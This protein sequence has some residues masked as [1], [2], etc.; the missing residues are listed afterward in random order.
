TQKKILIIVESI[1]IDNSS[2]AKGRVS[3]IKNLQR[4]GFEI[5]VLHYSKK[6]IH[7][8]NLKCIQ[9][10]E[11]KMT[12]WFLLSR[13][14]RHLRLTFKI[15]IHKPLEKIFG[16]SFTLFNDRKSIVSTLQELNNY[17]PD[18]VLTLS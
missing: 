15:D 4:A 9:I 8:D 10:A 12:G 13:I 16:F 1:D 11:R 5:K 3:L 14:E 17:E 6:E 2:G 7:L 18:L